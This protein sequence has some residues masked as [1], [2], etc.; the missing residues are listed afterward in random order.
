MNPFQPNNIYKGSRIKTILECLLLI[1]RLPIFLGLTLEIIIFNDILFRKLQNLELRPNIYKLIRI[2][3]LLHNFFIGRSLLLFIGYY[4]IKSIFKNTLQHQK[5]KNLQS[6][7]LLCSRTSPI[8]V[9]TL[10]TYFSPSFTH[11]SINKRQVHYQ[12]ISYYQAIIDSF[13]IEQCSFKQFKVGKD[14]RELMELI[15][16]KRTGPLIVFWE[17]GVS[18]G[19]YFLKI[20]DLMINEAYKVNKYS[21]QHQLLVKYNYSNPI[22]L[23]S[24][25]TNKRVNLIGNSWIK[26]LFNL[27]SNYY[28]D[29]EM[30]F[31]KLPYYSFSDYKLN[32][33]YYQF[34]NNQL[35]RK[36]S[37]KNWMDF[38]N[39]YVR[40][41]N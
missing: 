20:D 23:F 18:N 19:Q 35:K 9:F 10:I 6:Y 22:G 11:I 24:I 21:K 17:G 28:C 41:I 7:T 39:K 8:D 32:N 25:L 2:I 33:I 1:I 14:I 13:Y 29:L 15:D 30:F 38:I 27:L 12:L 4:N 5:Q 37:K 31:L 16:K 34:V 3:I 40:N 36:L 26:M